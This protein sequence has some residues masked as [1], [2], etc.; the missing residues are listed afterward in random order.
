MSTPGRDSVLYSR[1]EGARGSVD[2]MA[3]S[4]EDGGGSYAVVR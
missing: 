2:G 3:G 4:G 1:A